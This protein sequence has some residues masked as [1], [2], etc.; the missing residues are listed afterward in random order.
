MK[1]ILNYLT[2]SF[3]ILVF[4]ASMLALWQPWIFTW[5]S[6]K[7]ITIGLGIIMLGMGLTLTVN[8]FKRVVKFPGW[9]AIGMLLQYTVMPALGWGMS[10]VFHLPTVFAVGLILVACC[11]GGTASNVVNY[12]AKTDVPLSVTMTAISTIMGVF[13]TPFLTAFLAGSRIE[14]N[15]WGLL[16]DCFLVVVFPVAAGVALNRYASKFTAKIVPAAPLAAVIFI[17]LI[18]A[19]I[20]GAGRDM[21]LRSGL[22]LIGAVFSLHAGGFLFGYLFSKW[23]TRREIVSRTISVEVGMQNSGLG[24]VLARNN[25]TDPATA[26][27]CAMSSL[28]HCLIGSFLAGI[29]RIS[30]AS[31][32][33]GRS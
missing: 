1:K 28:T 18:V 24:V 12:L 8:D 3:P 23:L 9:V 5:F 13:M 21:I 26:I 27:P 16:T 30:S 4:A 2:N 14:V 20:I 10:F 11:P 32:K 15:A 25:F 17:V 33:E 6:G 29:W 31:Q 7:L 22:Q 19:S